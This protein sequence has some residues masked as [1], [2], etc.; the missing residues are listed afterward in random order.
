MMKTYK[1]HTSSVGD[2]AANMMAMLCYLILLCFW[3]S[4]IVFL[5]IVFLVEKKS[6][7]VRFHALQASMLWVLRTLLGG[8]LSFEG[9]AA[10]LTRNDVYLRNPLGWEGTPEVIIFR[11]AVGGAIIL[12]AVVAAMHAYKWQTWRVP[13]VGQLVAAVLRGCEQPMYGGGT[14]VPAECSMALNGR[15]GRKEAELDPL[16][17]RAEQ[18]WSQM[19][20]EAQPAAEPM[21]AVAVQA[22]VQ[23]DAPPVVAKAPADAGKPKARKGVFGRLFAPHGATDDF[24]QEIADAAVR[25]EEDAWELNRGRAEMPSVQNEEPVE[26]EAPEAQVQATEAAEQEARLA[27]SQEMVL[28]VL[29]HVMEAEEPLAVVEAPQRTPEPTRAISDDPNRQLP[30]DMRD[31]PMPTDML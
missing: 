27:D 20:A 6:G 17:P 7:L 12:L 23:E 13:F 15:A 29:S 14:E 5:L 25:P 11:T 9:M 30:P 1:P 22:P 16:E 24:L 31:P 4:G 3:S 2:A 18:D 21:M 26:A 28:R 8:G 10:V 19:Q